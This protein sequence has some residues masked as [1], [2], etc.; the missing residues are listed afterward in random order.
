MKNALGKLVVV[1]G[2]Q[3]LL[4]KNAQEAETNMGI[5]AVIVQ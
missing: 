1:L 4:L 3:S 5:H 2:K